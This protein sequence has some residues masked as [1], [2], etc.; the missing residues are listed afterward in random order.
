MHQG[1]RTDHKSEDKQLQKV[2]CTGNTDGE[3]AGEDEHICPLLSGEPLGL[4]QKTDCFARFQLCTNPIGANQ[5]AR[6]WK[7]REGW[8]RGEARSCLYARGSKLAAFVAVLFFSLSPLTATCRKNREAKNK[9][10]LKAIIVWEQQISHIFMIPSASCCRTEGD[11]DKDLA[12]S[13]PQ[14]RLA[15]CGAIRWKPDPSKK[16]ENI[17][18]PTH[19]IS[20]RSR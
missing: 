5:Q 12:S 9:T 16:K 4:R 15:L 6:R 11:L 20:S 7:R 2:P 17:I 14:R 8:N 13:E 19:P 18:Q 3:E 1:G 10:K